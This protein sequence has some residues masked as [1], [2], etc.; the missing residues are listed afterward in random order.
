MFLKIQEGNWRAT[1]PGCGP[2]VVQ[3]FM[4]QFFNRSVLQASRVELA[5]LQA[6]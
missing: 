4:P 2:G 6:W 3:A 1:L 5:V